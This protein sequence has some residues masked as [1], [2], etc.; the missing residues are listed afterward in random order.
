MQVT[1]DARTH[2][3]TII[4]RDVPV[5]ERDEEMAGLILDYD[6]E[7]NVVAMQIVAA[8]RRVAAPKARSGQWLPHLPVV[9]EGVDDAAQTP[10]EIVANC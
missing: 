3:P 6:A 2:T 9:P 1:F 10:A 5:S 4:L 8:R 7:G